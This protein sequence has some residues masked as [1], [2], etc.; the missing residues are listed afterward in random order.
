M[1]GLYIHNIYIDKNLKLISHEVSKIE[2]GVLIKIKKDIRTMKP[3]T[4]QELLV[5][6]DRILSHVAFLSEKKF[7]GDIFHPELIDYANRAYDSVMKNMYENMNF[8]V[9]YC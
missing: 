8:N 4:Y 3:E 6:S 2:N 5:K 7:D 9:R 1:I